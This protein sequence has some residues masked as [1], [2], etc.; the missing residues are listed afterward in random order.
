MFL[1]YVPA[2]KPLLIRVEPDKEYQKALKKE[3]EAFCFEMDETVKKL[4][5]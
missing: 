4:R 2:M 5:G 3:L 1:S